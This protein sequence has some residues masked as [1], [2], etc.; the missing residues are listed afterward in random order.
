MLAKLVAIASKLTRFK[1]WFFCLALASFVLFGA[2]LL[3]G[4][5]LFQDTPQNSD[6]VLFASSIV[7]LWSLLAL[8]L[9]NSFSH[10]SLDTPEKNGWFARLKHRMYQFFLSVLAI[11]LVVLTLL[12]VVMTIRLITFGF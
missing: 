3:F 7:M 5:S 8:I 11:V 2:S 1:A 12:S 4:D 6:S 10:L 9:I